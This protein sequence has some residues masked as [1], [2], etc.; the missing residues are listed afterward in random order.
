[1]TA[2]RRKPRVPVPGAI[3]LTPD[4]IRQWRLSKGW[5]QST[6]ALRLGVSTRTIARWEAGDSY[7]HPGAC[8][9]MARGLHQTVPTITVTLAQRPRQT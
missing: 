3:T 2:R 4:A 9:V 5:H 7:P 6:A 1:M 8:E